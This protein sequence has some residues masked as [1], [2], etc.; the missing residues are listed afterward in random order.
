MANNYQKRKT[1]EPIFRQNNS[2]LFF[3]GIGGISMSALAFMEQKAGK[4]C[5]GYDAVL[6]PLTD[7]LCAAGIPVADHFDPSLLD[8]VDLVIYTG[9]IHDDDPVRFTQSASPAFP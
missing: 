3:A 2:H 4:R 9:A 1:I 7:K 5:S 6:S 8:G